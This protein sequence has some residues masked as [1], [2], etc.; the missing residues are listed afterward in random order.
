MRSQL[1][2]TEE[3]R[4][5]GGV[6]L[7]THSGPSPKRFRIRLKIRFYSRAAGLVAG[8][9]LLM[10]W[11]NIPVGGSNPLPRAF[12]FFIGI[13]YFLHRFRIALH[14]IPKTL[15]TFV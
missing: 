15:P 2:V 13:P 4:R 8:T 1:S 12:R 10:R 6:A 9:A 14:E 11:D 5:T 3:T 7:K